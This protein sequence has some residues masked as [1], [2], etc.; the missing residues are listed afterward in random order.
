MPRLQTGLFEQ[1]VGLFSCSFLYPS[2]SSHGQ[3]TVINVKQHRKNHTQYKNARR[4]PRRR[5]HSRHAFVTSSIGKCDRS[6]N[7]SYPSYGSG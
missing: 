6:S 7:A 1:L 3:Y 2:H 4:V 5:S